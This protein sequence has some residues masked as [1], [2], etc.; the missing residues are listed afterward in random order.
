MLLGCTT[1]NENIE[2]NESK[3][4]HI[5]ALNKCFKYKEKRSWGN[6]CY[7]FILDDDTTIIIHLYQC[8]IIEKGDCPFCKGDE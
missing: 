6:G 4:V 1:N 2:N 8:L 3:H 7:Q 5:Y